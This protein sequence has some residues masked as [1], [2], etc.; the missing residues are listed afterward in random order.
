MK[1]YKMCWEKISNKGVTYSGPPL[2]VLDEEE[3]EYIPMP[4]EQ[5]D[6]LAEKFN[7]NYINAVHW[8]EELSDEEFEQ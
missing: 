7:Q 1:I 4:K 6:Q 8:I 3:L 5:A 2:V